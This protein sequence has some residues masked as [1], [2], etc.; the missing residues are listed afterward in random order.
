MIVLWQTNISDR[1]MDEYRHVWTRFAAAHGEPVMVL[2]HTEFNERREFAS[3]NH[4]N[5]RMVAFIKPSFIP[6]PAFFDELDYLWEAGV[7]IIVPQSYKAIFNPGEDRPYKWTSTGTSH[8]YV[9]FQLA[10][11]EELIVPPTLN[12]KY[13]ENKQ[14]D[15]IYRVPQNYYGDVVRGASLRS[16]LGEVVPGAFGPAGL[17]AMGHVVTGGQRWYTQNKQRSL[18]KAGVEAWAIYT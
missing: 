12:W 8:E 11:Q 17:R 2:P 15:A 14:L 18:W 10:G 9:I 5:G 4:K 6:S 1:A 7:H 16:N 13:L 3:I